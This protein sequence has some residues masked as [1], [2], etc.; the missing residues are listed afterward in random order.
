MAVDL[1]RL[2]SELR[3]DGTA[4]DTRLTALIAEATA[5]L[6]QFTR[7][8]LVTTV[9]TPATETAWTPLRERFVILYAARFYD[10]REDLLPAYNQVLELVRAER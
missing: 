6:Q 7:K 5:M 1:A 9:T 8:T 10:G 2:K 4:D 3:V